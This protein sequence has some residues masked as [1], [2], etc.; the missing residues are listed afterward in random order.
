MLNL[1]NIKESS[2]CE[3]EGSKLFNL[4]NIMGGERIRM[5]SS[6]GGSGGS[7]YDTAEETGAPSGTDTNSG[8]KWD[9]KKWHT[10]CC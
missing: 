4:S 8:G 3:F 6:K 9:D 5:S 1:E 2:F 10:T 7:A